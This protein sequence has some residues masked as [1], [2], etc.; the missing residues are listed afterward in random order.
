L[1]KRVVIAIDG[2]AA[3]GKGTLAHRLAAHYGLAC[4]DTGLLYRA[5]AAHLKD[6]S[7]EAAAV[8]V[9]RALAPSWL[10]APDLRGEQVGALASRIA[11]YPAL[12]AAL[13]RWQRDFA[14]DPAHARGSILD[15]RD[16]GTVICPDADLKFFVTASAEARAAR[17]YKELQESGASVIYPQI[18]QDIEARDARDRKRDVAPLIPAD[19]AI[20]IDSSDISADAVFEQARK[21]VDAILGL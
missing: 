5:V 16:I 13:R 10:T 9:A 12:R 4:L 15:G 7:D 17:R 6:R 2:P 3:A 20:V 1:A 18:L 8:A 11:A 19:D 14:H 21:C